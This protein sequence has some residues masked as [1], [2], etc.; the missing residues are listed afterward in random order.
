M[1]SF[2]CLLCRLLDLAPE[3]LREL[4]GKQKNTKEVQLS[5][6][7]EEAMNQSGILSLK[8]SESNQKQ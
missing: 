3:C 5:S 2:G 4:K 1:I 6:A 8:G 7:E